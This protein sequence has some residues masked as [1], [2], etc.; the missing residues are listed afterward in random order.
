[1][2]ESGPLDFGCVVCLARRRSPEFDG[3]GELPA[4]LEE[5]RE[6]GGVYVGSG[7]SF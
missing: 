5:A 6:A 2:S 7:R 3:P 4:C 1:M